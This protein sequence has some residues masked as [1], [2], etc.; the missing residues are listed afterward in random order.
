MSKGRDIFRLKQS[1]LVLPFVLVY[2]STDF[3]LVNIQCYFL[4]ETLAEIILSATWASFSPVKFISH[5]VGT[6]M[7]VCI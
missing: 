7:L 3:Y 2:P 4:L 6:Q 1:N 5:Y